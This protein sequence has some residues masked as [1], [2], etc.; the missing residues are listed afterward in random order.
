MSSRSTTPL[1]ITGDKKG[2]GILQNNMTYELEESDSKLKMH[3]KKLSLNIKSERFSTKTNYNH[4][5][6][7]PS[8]K[9]Q[10]YNQNNFSIKNKK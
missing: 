4:N 5:K 7:S 8:K 9:R 2:K 10:I 6:P 3:E 1:K